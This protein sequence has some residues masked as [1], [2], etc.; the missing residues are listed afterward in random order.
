VR[1]AALWI[2][3]V[4]AYAATLG[5]PAQT[6]TDYAGNEPHHLLAAESIVSDHNVDL[7]DEY[8]ERSYASWYPRELRTDGQIVAGR[9]MEPHGVGYA[10]LIAPA[11]AI[12][13]ARA[14][15]GQMLA[16]V[17]LAFVLGAA[18]ARRMVPEPWATAGAALVGLSPPALAASTTITPGV[19]AA[20][21]LSAA[22]L[23]AL[24]VR[25]RPRLGYVIGGALL[26]AGLPWLGWT[27]VVPG[28]IVAWALVVWTL[29][30]RR[31]LAALV[32]GEALAGSLVFYATVND[33]FYGGLTPRS[34]ATAQL[35]DFPLGYLERIP[36]LAGLWLDRGVGL[37]RWAPVLALVFFA[38]WLLYRSR[39]DQLARVAIARREAEACAGLLTCVAG[40]LVV[41]VALFSAGE[42]RGA[43]FPGVP[44]VA[45]LP[46]LAALTAWGLRHVP[47]PVA[48]VLA[49]FTLGASAWVV[50]AGRS[51][52]MT[53]WLQVDTKVPWG[54]PVAVF[55]DFT[56]AALWPALACGLIAA[57]AAA[58]W[59][60]ERRAAGE[61][62]R[63][64]AA[65]RTSKA[66][67]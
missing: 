21:L 52:R 50:L 46:A 3:L 37:L 20:V 56:G 65:S 25:E 9:L 51:G 40:S 43:T 66:L 44:L 33:R 23:C 41:V 58:L 5:I 15:Q 57:G 45:A 53:G 38:G 14:V 35:P 60:R 32:A 10:L 59:W 64:A 27:F 47:R 19:P 26:L 34:A 22:A 67:H 48:G 49:L 55:P 8:R 54:P 12:G 30:A 6:G 18:L 16:L 11:Y 7:A 13:G 1:L 29:R 61:W 62:R 39:R 2:L 24:A 63:A 42:L 36:R 28:V 31:R 4:A 17:A